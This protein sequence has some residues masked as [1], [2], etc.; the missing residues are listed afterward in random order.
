MISLEELLNHIRNTSDGN[1]ALLKEAK[2][3]YWLVSQADPKDRFGII[4]SIV[5][6]NMDTL[7]DICAMFD[8]EIEG[9][10]IDYTID[11]KPYTQEVEICDQE[12]MEIYERLENE[13]LEDVLREIM[14]EEYYEDIEEED[15]DI[16][17]NDTVNRLYDSLFGGQGYDDTFKL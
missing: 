2:E 6:P 3:M 9:F 4:Y 8:V 16:N 1:P 15:D 7:C 14:S 13:S 11:G 17:D 10:T 5:G 12:T